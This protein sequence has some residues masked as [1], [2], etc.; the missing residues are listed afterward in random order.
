MGGGV[1]EGR[2]AL[3]IGDDLYRGSS[4]KTAC[5]DNKC[6]ASNEEFLCVELEV[7]GFD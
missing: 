2:F 4:H 7:W 3:Y 6:L 1:Q 5:F